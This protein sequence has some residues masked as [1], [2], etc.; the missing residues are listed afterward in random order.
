MHPLSNTTLQ[1]VIRLFQEGEKMKLVLIK[2]NEFEQQFKKALSGWESINKWYNNLL[3][4]NKQQYPKILDSIRD[5]LR[6][7]GIILPVDEMEFLEWFL[8]IQHPNL[9]FG[10]SLPTIERPDFIRFH[11]YQKEKMDAVM[12]PVSTPVI[13]IETIE[14][15]TDNLS[16]A[17]C[18]ILHVYLSK[19]GGRAITKQNQNVIAKEYGLHADSSGKHLYVSFQKY[20]QDSE[21]LNIHTSNKKAAKE[22]IKRFEAILPMLENQSTKAFTNAKK[23]LEQLI[24]TYERHY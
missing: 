16:I 22:H 10:Q 8:D 12:A 21:R 4:E 14:N 15:T 1:N 11:K 2:S 18:A 6:V 7:T 17:S 23:D 5:N 9:L 19:N 3:K 13:E 20:K 24:S